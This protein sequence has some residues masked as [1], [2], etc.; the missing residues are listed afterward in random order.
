[1]H[2]HIDESAVNSIHIS[3]GICVGFTLLSLVLRILSRRCKGASLAS[4]DYEI[5]FGFVCQSRKFCPHD[6]SD[7]IPTHRYFTSPLSQRLELIH[8]L[9]WVIMSFWLRT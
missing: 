1:M 8:A 9:D 7:I 2:E 5:F 6:C 4:D 3:S